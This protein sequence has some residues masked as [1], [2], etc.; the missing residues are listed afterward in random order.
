M[1]Q[2]H[3]SLGRLFDRYR[4]ACPD[5][6][7][8]VSFMPGLWTRI[9][10]RR[11]WMWHLRSYTQ[12]MVAAATLASLV[13]LGVHVGRVFNQESLVSRSWVDVL[14]ENSAPED[15]AYLPVVLQGDQFE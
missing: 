6:E 7:A 4:E 1:S 5:V 2:Q 9:D 13:L 10:A 3:D 14:Q 15:Y 11:G 12:R 8:S